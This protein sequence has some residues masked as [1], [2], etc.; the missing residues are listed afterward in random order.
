MKA[1]ELG[2]VTNPRRIAGVRGAR[3][4]ATMSGTRA[5]RASSTRVFPIAYT[6]PYSSDAERANVKLCFLSPSTEAV[7]SIPGHARTAPRSYS[8]LP[9]PRC[10]C[11]DYDTEGVWNPRR[12]SDA[13]EFQGLRHPTPLFLSFLSL[14]DKGRN[15]AVIAP[16]S[17]KPDFFVYVRHMA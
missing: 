6:L 9:R 16:F 1:P 3:R 17:A 4:N 15:G 8:S 10:T 7:Y 14:S 13:L 11:T 12:N 2:L 5:N